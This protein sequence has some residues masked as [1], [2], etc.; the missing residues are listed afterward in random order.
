MPVAEEP[1]AAEVLEAVKKH[2]R[3]DAISDGDAVKIAAVF[4]TWKSRIGRQVKTGERLWFNGCLYKVMRDHTVAEERQPSIYTLQ[5]YDQVG[6]HDRGRNSSDAIEFQYG[7]ALVQG[8][9]YKDD[10]QIY[11]CTMSLPNCTWDLKHLVGRFV[12]TVVSGSE[13]G[14]VNPENGTDTSSGKNPE[15]SGEEAVT[16]FITGMKLVKGRIYE[17]TGVKYHCIRDLSNCM[18]DLRHLVGEYVEK[19]QG[20]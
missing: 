6:T 1:T 7:M 11:L 18:W 10:G 2:I 15:T 3:T 8:R 9:Y 4:P 20:Q 16:K 17:Q 13:N 5:L 19:I 14:T 12:E